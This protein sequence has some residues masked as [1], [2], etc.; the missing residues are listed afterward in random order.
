MTLLEEF[1]YH[2]E[3]LERLHFVRQDR[4]GTEAVPDGKGGVVVP[5]VHYAFFTVSLDPGLD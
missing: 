1:V 3:R 2:D 4:L 5:C